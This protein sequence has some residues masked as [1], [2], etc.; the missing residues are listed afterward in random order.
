MDTF[1]VP[2]Q[3]RPLG[4]S[5]PAPRTYVRFLLGMRDQVILQ[6]M[7]SAEFFAAYGTFERL[8]VCVGSQ[9]VPEGIRCG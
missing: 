7:V 8:V 2:Q 6:M 9:V 5:L 1:H 4:E 3:R